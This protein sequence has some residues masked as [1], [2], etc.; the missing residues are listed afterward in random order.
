MLLPLHVLLLLFVQLFSLGL[1]AAAAY[2]LVLA[3]RN[4]RRHRPHL[5][6]VPRHTTGT[7]LAPVGVQE[8]VIP[9]ASPWTDTAVLA[10]L[11]LGLLLPLLSLGGG[12]YLVQSAFPVGSDEP[13]S[14]RNT[15]VKNVQGTGG[16]NLHVEMHGAG[17]SPTLLFT[18]GWSMN[19]SEWFYADRVLAD[20][21]RV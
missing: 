11:V 14:L 2:A 18:H 1:L 4:A 9:A 5:A 7:N 17:D 21:H 6:H 15:A 16:A 10:P 20:K 13:Q 3:V 8:R 12:R 19:D